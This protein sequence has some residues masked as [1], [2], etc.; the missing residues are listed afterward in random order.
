MNGPLSPYLLQLLFSTQCSSSPGAI[1]YV[2]IR[3]VL[4]TLSGL[5]V[6]SYSQPKKFHFQ[7]NVFNNS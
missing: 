1:N 5:T 4:Q 2:T 6:D 7:L 3:T